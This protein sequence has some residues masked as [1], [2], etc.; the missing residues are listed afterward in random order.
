MEHEQIGVKKGRHASQR[1]HFNPVPITLNTT[2]PQ[3]PLTRHHRNIGNQAVQRLMESQAIQAKLTIGRPN[4]KYEQ[5]ADR[6]ADQV[7]RMPEGSL[8]NGHSSLVQRQSTC[9]E[10]MEEE[11][12]A[13]RTKPL[14]EQITP[15]IQRQSAPEEEEEE[16]GFIQTRGEGG[17]TPEVTSGIESRIQSLTGGGQPLQKS[18][19]DFFEP[20]FG[21]DFN[22]VRV[23][24]DT[25]AAQIARSIHAQAFTTKNNIVFNKNKYS[26]G[27]SAGK[28]LLAHE[29]AHVVQ[30]GK[31]GP[32]NNDCKR[33]TVGNRLTK[34]SPGLK[35]RVSLSPQI[36]LYAS[37]ICDRPSTQFPDFPDTYIS[38]IDLDLTSPN[39]YVTLTWTG[40]NASSGDTGP[41]HSSPGAGLCSLDCDDGPSSRRS[42][43]C[44]TPKGSRSV[45]KYKCVMSGHPTATNVTYFHW[46]RRIAFHYFPSVPNYPASHGCVRLGLNAARLIYDN[47]RRSL[48]TVNVGGTW[49]GTRCYNNCS[50]DRSRPR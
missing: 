23:H 48:T 46:D 22:Q 10:C 38:Q 16:E 19:R 29:L 37:R 27:T 12:G 32:G 6:V 13:V 39:H 25:R 33:K 1:S 31:A 21:A 15:L 43:S 9:P 5:E 8:V 30:Q 11:E 18:T 17:S 4:D 42:G 2:T 41:F 49:T 20:R 47:S 50:D 3:S 44:C 7:M 36:Q 26:S 14:A 35:Q 40:P 45:E 24:T 34:D 28:H